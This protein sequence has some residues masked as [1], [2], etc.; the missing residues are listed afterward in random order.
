MLA[1]FFLLSVFCITDLYAENEKRCL[2][3]KDAVQAFLQPWLRK[4]DGT[5]LS[6]IKKVAIEPIA[7]EYTF[8]ADTSSVKLG[9]GESSFSGNVSWQR[10][11]DLLRSDSLRV[12]RDAAGDITRWKIDEPLTWL[13][14]D[15]YIQANT[16]QYAKDAG[17]EASDLL[18]LLFGSSNRRIWGWAE[19]MEAQQLEHAKMQEVFMT[20]C[21][22]ESMDWFIRSPKL[23]WDAN[24]KL[25]RLEQPKFYMMNT[26][27]FSLNY[28]DIYLQKKHR[29]WTPKFDYINSMFRFGI[30][31]QQQDSRLMIYP[32]H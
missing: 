21:T 1:L 6:N 8:Q 19:Q 32:Y 20:S 27:M 18:F 25:L 9:E 28:Y 22:P 23:V 29:T 15:I 10:K 30:Q 16:A 3:T 14:K 13:G 31:Y 4:A 24:K 26:Y 12:Y 17:Y 7:E 2:A 5:C 11:D